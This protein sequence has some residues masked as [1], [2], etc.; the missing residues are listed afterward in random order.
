MMFFKNKKIMVYCKVGIFQFT[1]YF[2][3]VSFSIIPK[4][5]E[6]KI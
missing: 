4:L 5:L 6:T 3:Y 1:K 2:E